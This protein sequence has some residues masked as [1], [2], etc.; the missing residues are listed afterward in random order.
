MRTISK[1]K[2]NEEFMEKLLSRPTGQGTGQDE[3]GHD[4]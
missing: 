3:F 1:V 2:N 4:G